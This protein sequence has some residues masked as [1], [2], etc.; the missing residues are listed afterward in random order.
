M[1]EEEEN[2]YKYIYWLKIDFFNE[3]EN[4]N[5]LKKF[6]EKYDCN[7]QVYYYDSNPFTRKVI[8]L[9]CNQ[10]YQDLDLDVNSSFDGSLIRLNNKPK[11]IKTYNKSIELF[12][13]RYIKD[14][15][16]KRKVRTNNDY[17]RS[18]KSIR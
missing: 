7:M 2:K 12:F 13:E 5:N 15:N 18:T 6:K 1:G 17:R 8:K 10:A 11:N 3:N 14:L 16:I 4:W 9:E